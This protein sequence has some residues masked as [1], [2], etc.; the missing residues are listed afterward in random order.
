MRPASTAAFGVGLALAVSA[1]PA[2]AWAQDPKGY[3]APFADATETRVFP[4]FAMMRTADGWAAALRGDAALRKLAATRAARVPADGCTPSPQCLAEAWTWTDAD[5][6]TVEAR[7]RLLVGDRRLAGALVRGQM[8]P[9]GR[10][11]RHAALADAHL[12]AT[13]WGEA[14][15]AVNR[16]IAVYA[17]GVAPRY[18]TIDSIIFDAARPEFVDVLTAHGVATA[19]RVHEGDLFFAPSLRYAVGLLQMNERTEAGSYRPLLGG[20]NAAS[21]RAIA[22]MDWQARPYTALLV[23]GHGP[24]DAQSRT[25]VMGHIRM[26]IAADMFARGLAP[27]II[28][29]GG[30]VH[31][32]RTP[33]NEAIEMKRLLVTEHGIPADRILIEPHARHTTT[34]LRNCARLLL[35]AGFPVDRPALI[36]SDHRTIQYIGGGE[37]AQRNLREMGVQPGRLAPGPDRFSLSFTPAPIAFHIEAAD[38]LDP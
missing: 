8:R 3:A 2:V 27:F 16:V 20:E 23:F 13:A 4:L 15:A 26:R 38:P 31:P 7:L 14:A 1:L 6:A 28:V 30:N 21:L 32:N 17:K 25:G 18:P 5:I 10:F 22:A 37:L 11:A 9:S 24:E 35:A 19:T 29:S 12:V 36:V 34:N 33:F